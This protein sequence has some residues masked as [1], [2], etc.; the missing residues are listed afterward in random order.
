MTTTTVFRVSARAFVTQSRRPIKIRG[1]WN[2]VTDGGGGNPVTIFIPSDESYM[3]TSD[4]RSKLASICPWES[5]F[6]EPSAELEKG[7]ASDEIQSVFRFFMPSGEEVSFCGHAAIGACAF[8]ANRNIITSY[9]PNKIQESFL[10]TDLPSLDLVSS[11]SVVSFITADKSI[12]ETKVNG[13][14]AELVMHAQHVETD[15][16]RDK[17]FRNDTATMEDFLDVLG[18]STE[19]I[20]SLEG[21]INWPTFI[22][23]SVARPKTLIPIKSLDRLHSAT[24]PADPEKFCRL[25]ES[26]D[27]TGIYIYAKI[28][29]A[30]AR[31][32]ETK[33][34]S[35]EA[36]QFPKSS[37]YGEDPATGIAAG[38][39][40]AS[41]HKRGITRNDFYDIF[42][43]TA[44]GKPSRIG[45]KLQHC[46]GDSVQ[47][48]QLTMRAYILIY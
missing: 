38:A 36:R 15:C 8:L 26:I 33:G 35:F 18:L 16:F 1:I 37:G 48:E 24:S 4:E 11:S 19:D 40:A 12:F 44:M 31:G 39:L 34:L 42:Q 47:A 7:Q 28:G 29:D 14:D 13:N 45:V 27:S 6:I 9:Q 43:G 20:S 46:Q 3:L 2:N 25:C 22:N 30:D 10:P 21:S 23:S 5:V 17:K 41:L 32:E